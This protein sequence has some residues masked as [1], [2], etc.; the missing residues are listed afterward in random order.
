MNNEF[1]G[2]I[3]DMDGTLIDRWSPGD[4]APRITS[5]NVSLVHQIASNERARAAVLTNQGGLA[6]RLARVPGCEKYPD[7]E[8]TKMRLAY[9][10]LTTGITRFL[11]CVYHPKQRRTALGWALELAGAVLPPIRVDGA[12]L[13]FGSRFRKPNE[14]GVRWLARRLGASPDRIVYYGDS[15]DDAGA[16]AAGGVGCFVLV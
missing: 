4:N 9:V 10:A 13:A 5:P 12:W 15:D 2:Y 1:D 11:L 14:A 6:L 8:D 3:F 16:A 7:W